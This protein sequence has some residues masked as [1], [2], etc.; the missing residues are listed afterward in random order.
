MLGGARL[1]SFLAERYGLGEAFAKPWFAL[2]L[3]FPPL[4]MIFVFAI[5]YRYAPNT[6][7]QGWQALMPGTFVGVAVWLV[8]TAVFRLYLSYFGAYGKTYGS[9]GAVIILML[10][11]YLSGAAMLIGGVVNSEIRQAAAAAGAAAAR[12]PI[13]AD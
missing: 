1:G 9:L 4:F 6:R 13:D 12:E 8:A 10:W 7:A 11:L 2:Q 3:T 5:I